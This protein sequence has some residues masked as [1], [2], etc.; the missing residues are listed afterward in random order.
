MSSSG[1]TLV[2]PGRN[3]SATVEKCL[4]SV[5]GLREQSQ[6]EEIIFVDDG[7]TDDTADKVSK[8]DVRYIKGSG[9]GAGSA[10]NLGWRAAETPLVWFIDS[11]CVAEPN[12]L[13]ILMEHMNDPLVAGVGGSYTNL[14]P[15][16]LLACL[17]QEEIAERHL[18]MRQEVNFL[19]TFN[20]L[21]RREQLEAVNGFDERFAKAQD[22]ELAFRIRARGGRLLFDPRSRVGHHHPRELWPYLKTQKQQGY[23]RAWLY[24][25]YPEKMSGD[26]YSGFID[27]IQPPLAMLSLALLPLGPLALAAGPVMAALGA[28]QAP[29]T[30]RLVRRTGDARYCFFGPM[31]FIR[32][33]AR[34]IGMSQGILE[35]AV[36]RYHRRWRFKQRD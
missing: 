17:I 1:I 15:E 3:V 35:A 23:W 36:S 22:A 2:I 10:R 8:F 18:A 11:D 26:S 33:Y 4:Q 27:H 14:F 30:W 25:E 29:M 12:A 6:L 7:S 31:S 16:S 20:V 24:F 5:V 32:A 21:Y 13:A 34:G 28:A 19:A 9:Q